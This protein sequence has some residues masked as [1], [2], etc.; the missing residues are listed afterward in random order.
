MEGLKNKTY[1]IFCGG[2]SKIK[3]QVKL[4]NNATN[5]L[6]L[7]AFRSYFMCMQV[8]LLAQTCDMTISNRRSCLLLFFA[9]RMVNQFNVVGSKTS[10]EKNISLGSGDAA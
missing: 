10:S 1:S 2:L 8:C 5:L 4:A 9:H 6:I 7:L 3:I